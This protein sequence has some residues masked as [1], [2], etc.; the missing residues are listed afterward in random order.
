ML[1]VIKKIRRTDYGSGYNN[2]GYDAR[3]KQLHS[4][5]EQLAERKKT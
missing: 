5:I 4:D 2:V 3:S 1:D